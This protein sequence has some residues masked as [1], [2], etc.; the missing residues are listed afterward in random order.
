MAGK[1]LFQHEGFL[2][3]TWLRSLNDLTNG[4]IKVSYSIGIRGICLHFRFHQTKSSAEKLLIWGIW[5]TDN[6]P[7]W[8]GKIYFFV[9]TE[10]HLITHS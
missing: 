2:L 7:F 4:S 3:A 10:P 1:K 5:G 8:C 6:T 9:M